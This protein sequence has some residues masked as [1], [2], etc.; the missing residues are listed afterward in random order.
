M[1]YSSVYKSRNRFDCVIDQNISLRNMK[2]TR[3]T[4]GRTVSGALVIEVRMI[5]N[6]RER[7]E[8][9]REREREREGERW[10]RE[11]VRRERE[12]REREKER[13]RSETNERKRTER[14]M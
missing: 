13:G 8:R 9:E 12:E 6:E 10:R 14:G 11:R 5:V 4:L 7:G 2:Q 3:C 1:R